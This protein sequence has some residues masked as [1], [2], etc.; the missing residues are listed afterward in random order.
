MRL[1]FRDFFLACLFRLILS[2]Q[3]VEF[4][5]AEINGKQVTVCRVNVKKEHLELFHRDETGQPIKRFEKL[6]PWLEKQGRKLVFAMTPACTTAIFLRS[7][8]SCLAAKNKPR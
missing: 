5:T 4:S 3:A 7:G 6:A 8:C 1:H 2:A